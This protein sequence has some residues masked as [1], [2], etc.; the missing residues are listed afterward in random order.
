MK[1]L[2]FLFVISISV[3]AQSD[4]IN[5]DSLLFLEEDMYDVWADK[6]AEPVGGLD[7]LQSRLI[8][9]QDALN[10]NIEGK[11]YVLVIIDSTGNQFCARVIK[12]LGYGCDD[13]A[14]R[15]VRTSQFIPGV[16]RRKPQTM[17]VSIPIVF[18]LKENKNE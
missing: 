4:L 16:F 8:Y 9:P 7:S 12:S 3:F 17:K 10:N 6:M 11:V 2:A 5:C 15:L 1:T 13:E 14:L 18:S